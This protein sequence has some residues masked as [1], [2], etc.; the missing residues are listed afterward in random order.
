MIE[1][2]TPPADWVIILPVVLCLMGAA[3]LLMLRG[4]LEVQLW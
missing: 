1:H 3:L 2:V 4:A